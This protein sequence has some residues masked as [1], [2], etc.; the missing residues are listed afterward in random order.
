MKNSSYLSISMVTAFY[1]ANL[2]FNGNVK[3]I[4]FD[5]KLLKTIKHSDLFPD[6]KIEVI[7]EYKIRKAA[8]AVVFDDEGKIAIIKVANHN[9]HKLP[10]GGVE[11][12]DDLASAL[13]REMI[14]EIGC[15]IL[16]TGDI[17]RIVEYRDKWGIRQ[18]SFCY[19]AKLIGEK[20]QPEFTE[21]EIADGFE[22]LWISLEEAIEKIRKD[23][24]DD[25][26][27]KLV[28]V[29]DLCFLEEA[30]ILQKAF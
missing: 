12:G 7:G 9:Y 5:M 6:D 30:K 2:L 29:R 20:G 17:G 26:L 18:E 25:Y 23:N 4:K 24:P 21:V 27:G 28:T 16:V 19:I 3:E 11:A 22:V 13:E 15:K 10:G 1:F 14:E 8:R